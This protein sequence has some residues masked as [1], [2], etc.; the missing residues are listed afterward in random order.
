MQQKNCP[1]MHCYCTLQV[2]TGSDPGV[3]GGGGGGGL[4]PEA[5][6]FKMEIFI[7]FALS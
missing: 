1:D 2:Y 3:V 4:V 5:P 7:K 6:P